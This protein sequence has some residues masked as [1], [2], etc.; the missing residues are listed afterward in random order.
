M[1]SVDWTN[2]RL[3][4]SES[5]AFKSSI[6]KLAL[7]LIDIAGTVAQNQFD[8]ELKRDTGDEDSPGIQDLM[9][10]VSE[11]LPGWL[12]AVIGDRVAMAQIDAT[13]HQVY[14][15]VVKLERSHAPASAIMAAQIRAGKELLLIIER[16][17]KYAQTYLT[18]NTELDP[19]VSALSRLVAAD[20]EGFA[21]V[22][23]LREAIDEA[24]ENIRGTH[25]IPNKPGGHDIR[26]HILELKNRA[27]VFQRCDALWLDSGRLAREGNAIVRRWDA[28][29][30]RPVPNE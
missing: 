9:S 7:R 3:L 2:I 26:D 8:R 29:L 22:I 5:Q 28:E 16:I 30:R 14:G 25:L 21:L 11:L 23:P 13:W 20:P 4:D 24:M 17:H 15:P 27:R 19:L 1:Q 12:D 18:R 10:K 6:N